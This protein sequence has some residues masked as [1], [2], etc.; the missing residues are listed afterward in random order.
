[1][2]TVYCNRLNLESIISKA[3]VLAC[4]DDDQTGEEGTTETSYIADCITRAAV[5]MNESLRC[6]YPLANLA[7]N[8]WC[9]WCNAYLACWFLFERRANPVPPGIIDAVQTYR[10]RLSE[11]RWGRFQVPEVSPAFDYAPSVT[12]F[13][14]ELGHSVAPIRVDTDESTTT[15]PQPSRKRFTR[16][17]AWW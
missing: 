16:D 3:G 1:M 17:T 5:E 9:R 12:N 15:A 2:A 10:E 7:S 14:P 4:V 6:Q 13:V 11:I 8:D